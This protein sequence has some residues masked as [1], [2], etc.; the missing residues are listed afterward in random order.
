MANAEALARPGSSG[1]V[2]SLDALRGVVMLVMVFVND[3]GGVRG[4]PWWS[5]HFQPYEA[6]G[7]TFVD[8]VFP[9]FLFVMGMSIP[10]ALDNR[11]ARGVSIWRTVAH[12][13]L[14][15]GMLLTVGVFMVNMGRADQ[16]LTWPKGLWP[17]LSFLSAILFCLWIPREPGRRRIT[18]IVAKTVGALGLT[19]LFILY[20]G[21]HSR[22][23]ETDWWGILGLLGWAYLA[24]STAWLGAGR[25]RSALVAVQSMLLLLFILQREG[26]LDHWFGSDYL[27]LGV[28][29]GSHGAIAVLGALLGSILLP[30]SD[31]ST[32]RRRLGFASAM[33]VLL[34]MAAALFYPLYGLNK[35]A[36]T[37]SWALLSAA[38]TVVLFIPLYWLIDDRGWLRWA[39]LLR[40]AG[41]SALMIYLLQ[42]VCHRLMPLAHFDLHA[43]LGAHGFGWACCR[44]AGVALILTLVAACL[45]RLGVRL[46]L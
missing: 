38:A 42:S 36:A 43:R 27:N 12:V 25:A 5:Q 7:M 2:H 29:I 8:W 6:N 17:A 4:A 33:A 39:W 18:L 35:D 22:W 20:R 24:A 30:G 45:F 13:L 3:I 44:G 31:I 26:R 40:A 14:R 37:P 32:T 10:V 9:A 21:P 34:L 1:R 19:A 15:G 23:M 46:R 11:R 41:T 16:G 28:Q